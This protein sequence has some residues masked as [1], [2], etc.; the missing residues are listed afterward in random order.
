MQI[1]SLEK[2]KEYEKERKGKERKGKE[3][4]GKQKETEVTVYNASKSNLFPTTTT[5]IT[6]KVT[7]QDKNI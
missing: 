3:R 5:N 4:K 7:S 6:K 1:Q 2:I